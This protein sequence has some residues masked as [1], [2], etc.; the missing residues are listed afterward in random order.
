MQSGGLIARIR[1]AIAALFGISDPAAHA[2]KWWEIDLIF[3]VLLGSLAIGMAA[4]FEL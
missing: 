2:G 1:G 4:W 3:V